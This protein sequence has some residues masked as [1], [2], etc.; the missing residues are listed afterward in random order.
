[1]KGTFAI[2]A[3]AAGASA[4][5]AHARHNHALAHAKKGYEVAET[6]GCT[7]V[8]STYYGQPTRT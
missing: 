5:S 4:G 8:Y 7:T 3:L 2:A 1:M 6:C